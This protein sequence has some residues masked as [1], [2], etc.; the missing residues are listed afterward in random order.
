MQYQTWKDDHKK[1]FQS[2]KQHVVP[3]QLDLVSSASKICDIRFC[4]F[5]ACLA[6][7]ST[8]FCSNYFKFVN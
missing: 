3:K 8:Y 6:L 1:I 4:R 5:E 2:T 7:P